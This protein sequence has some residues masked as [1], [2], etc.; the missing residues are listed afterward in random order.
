MHAHSYPWAVATPP[1]VVVARAGWWRT[2]D[3]RRLYTVERFGARVVNLADI[4]VASGLRGDLFAL[5]FD[6]LDEQGQSASRD[7]EPKLDSQTF[8]KGWLDVET[9]DASWD[10]ADGV[11]LHWH[12]KRVGTIVAVNAVPRRCPRPKRRW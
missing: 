4:W 8:A 9:R 11:A 7:G 5:A 10:D 6:L 12:L 2:V 1:R 3:L